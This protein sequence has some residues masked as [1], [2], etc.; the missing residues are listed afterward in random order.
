MPSATGANLDYSLLDQLEFPFT[1]D[2][3]VSPSALAPF[4]RTIDSDSVC[5]NPG[6]I[7]RKAA[8]GTAALLSFNQSKS[9]GRDCVAER[10]R[11]DFIQF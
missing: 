3:I 5:L 4:A 10:L 8:R 2:I 1:P 9:V 11:V 7:C 6:P